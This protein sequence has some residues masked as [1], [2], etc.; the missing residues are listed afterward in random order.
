MSAFYSFCV[1]NQ[2][3]DIV[4][5]L[6]L[7]HLCL[8]ISMRT[9]KNFGASTCRTGWTSFHHQWDCIAALVNM[10]YSFYGKT[11]AA[12]GESPLMEKPLAWFWWHYCVWFQD[13]PMPFFMLKGV[14]FHLG[15]LSH[16]AQRSGARLAYL[17]VFGGDDKGF[18]ACRG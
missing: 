9:Q 14:A 7:T 11:L 1:S 8:N 13:L 4:F 6:R 3:K 17:R 5:K 16:T 15:Q 12:E 2:A 18:S 10:F